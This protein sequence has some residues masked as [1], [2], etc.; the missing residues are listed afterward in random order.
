MPSG[1]GPLYIDI[2][3]IPDKTALVVWMIEVRAF[4]NE[5][6]HARKVPGTMRKSLRD[7]E[8]LLVLSGKYNTEPLS[9]CFGIFTK[10]N[11]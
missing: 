2:L 4:V 6:P 1:I 7:K 9:V 11:S 5:T 8:L 10:V 3:V